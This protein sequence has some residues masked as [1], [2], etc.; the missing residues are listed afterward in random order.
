MTE[1]GGEHRFHQRLPGF[2]IVAVVGNVML[3]SQLLESPDGAA[4]G[5]GEVQVGKS[6]IQGR[7]GVEDARGA[8]LPVVPLDEPPKRVKPPV[9]AAKP[10]G[11][12]SGRHV[13]H[14]QV[15]EALSPPE[16]L[17]VGP[18]SGNRVGNGFAVGH[19]GW[20][21]QR[22]HRPTAVD[23]YAGPDLLV[24]RNQVS[25]QQ[26]GEESRRDDLPRLGDLHGF[27]EELPPLNLPPPEH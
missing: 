11:G 20:I 23:G 21:G 22:C 27:V 12:L 17:E 2:P 1:H 9:V 26:G 15:I 8:S 25:A 6:T 24:D 13:D 14:D 19:E 3:R 5:G 4:G 10:D 18:E 7:I 16:R